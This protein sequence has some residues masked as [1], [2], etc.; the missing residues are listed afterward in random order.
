M[1]YDKEYFLTF[2][3]YPWFKEARIDQIQNV[4]LIHDDH[5]HW[6][7]LDVDLEISSLDNLEKYPLTYK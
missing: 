3:Q 2:A 6:P 5:L 4:E 1:V 7:D